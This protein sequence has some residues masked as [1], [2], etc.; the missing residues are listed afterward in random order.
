M[1]RGKLTAK[2]AEFWAN[3]QGMTFRD[4]IAIQA[5]G[6]IITV[7]SGSLL[8]D[9]HR[10]SF[11]AYQVADDMLATRAKGPYFNPLNRKEENEERAKRAR[12]VS[13]DTI[14]GQ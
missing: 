8:E 13:E 5:L 6:P 3:L 2:E 9:R 14:N 4:Y 1:D 7:L 12:R 10:L 11:L